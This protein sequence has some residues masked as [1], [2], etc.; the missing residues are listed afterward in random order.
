MVWLERT[1]LLNDR[2]TV[3]HGVHLRPHEC[4]ALAQAGAT[5]A[6][7]VSSNLRLA[8]GIAPGP[9]IQAAGLPFGLGLD[10]LAMA[11]DDDML[12][13]VRLAARL[14]GGFGHDRNGPS[15]ASCFR[16]AASWGWRTIDGSEGLGLVEG[17]PA[18]L[19]VLN[20]ALLVADR[21]GDEGMP[22]LIQGRMAMGSVLDVYARGR[23]IV[24]NGEPT[25]VDLCEME[26]ELNAQARHAAPSQELT[27]ILTRAEAA[28][29]AAIRQAL[30][31]DLPLGES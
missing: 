29:T 26:R 2:L 3:A 30:L 16:A 12:A 17:A 19:L 1:G 15:A 22:E 10:G 23:Q 14:L 7:N 5:L 9:S 25:G 13:E 31:A 18:D 21:L 24:R 8:S 11:D 28:S 27:S 4:R 20:E 6:V